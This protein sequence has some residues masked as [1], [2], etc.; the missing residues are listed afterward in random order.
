MKKIISI[1]LLMGLCLF[2]AGGFVLAGSEEAI[3]ATVFAKVVSISIS[4][5]SW[6]YGGLEFGEAVDTYNLGH[7]IQ[8][9]NNGTVPVDV[10]V[11]TDNAMADEGNAWALGVNPAN[12]T[13][14]YEY[15][16][17]NGGLWTKYTADTLY[18]VD[19]L[20]NLGA[21]VMTPFDQRISMPTDASSPLATQT[22]ITTALATAH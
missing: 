13:F 8:L 6:N 16:W 17:N 5:S 4:P 15:S 19:A 7:Y 22:I 21:G 14:R 18:T 9:T 10:A 3:N 11:K 12:D 2:S 20:V 1:S